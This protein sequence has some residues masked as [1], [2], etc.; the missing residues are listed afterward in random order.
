MGSPNATTPARDATT[1]ST[2]AMMEALPGST[3]LRPLVYRMYGRTVENTTSPSRTSS[4][5]GFWATT[6][7]SAG[8]KNSARD[9][10][11]A[12]MKVQTVTVMEP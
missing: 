3:W 1:T 10:G 12:T 5:Q 7:S 4:S 9:T 2:L 6:V 11:P 8:R